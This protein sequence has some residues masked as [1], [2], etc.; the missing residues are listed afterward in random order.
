MIDNMKD[1]DESQLL[2]G[3]MG[4]LYAYF[5]R[6]VMVS[7]IISNNSMPHIN[8]EC[9]LNAEKIYNY[10]AYEAKIL[11]TKINEEANTNLNENESK[12]LQML[13]DKFSFQDAKDIC[14]E[15]K[16]SDKFFIVAF[17][18]KYKNGHVVRLASKTYQKLA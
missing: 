17:N 3:Y 18:R 6:F 13:P 5:G 8:E 2:I 7:A 12:L 14:R 1:G 10:F 11:L 4:K 16:L 9:V 15:L